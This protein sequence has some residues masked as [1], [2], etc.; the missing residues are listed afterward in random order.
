MIAIDLQGTK[1]EEMRTRSGQII[2]LTFTILDNPYDL[3][4]AILEFVVLRVNYAG[5][6]LLEIT[7]EITGADTFRVYAN[8]PTFDG[9]TG[10]ANYSLT[11]ATDEGTR[12]LLEGTITIL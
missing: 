9:Y 6:A 10:V 3:D 11:I 8:N 7:P 2:D 5:A 4:T 12:S 1:N